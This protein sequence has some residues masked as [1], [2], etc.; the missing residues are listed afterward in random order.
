VDFSKLKLELYDFFGIVLPGLLVASEGWILLR[1]WTPFIVAVSKISGPGLTLLI[2]FGFGL[3]HIVQ[4]L[5]D[6]TVKLLKGKRYFK[7]GRDKFWKTEEANL[8]KESI[9]VEFGRVIESVDAAFDYCLTK[10][11]ARFAKRD[12]FMA[13]SDLCRS[14]VVLALIGILPAARIAFR[15]GGS[16]P[17]LETFGAFLVLLFVVATLAW[18]RMARFRELAD[19]TVF[20]A[21]LAVRKGL[22]E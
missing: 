2:I 17:S 21:Y 5:G 22:T 9:E 11:D 18:V 19:V 13:T 6:V 15:E 3:G 12:V 16:R 4:E 8:V 10:L 14:L 20:R 1:G 7:K